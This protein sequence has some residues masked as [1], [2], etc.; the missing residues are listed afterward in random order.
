MRNKRMLLH[1]IR[2]L[3]VASFFFLEFYTEGRRSLPICW[4]RRGWKLGKWRLPARRWGWDHIHIFQRPRHFVLWTSC[5]Y[6][7]HQ[8]DVLEDTIHNGSATQNYFAVEIRIPKKS[9]SEIT[10]RT[11]NQ[12]T[13]LFKY[14]TNKIHHQSAKQN[15]HQLIKS[16]LH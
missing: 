9:Y 6:K 16:F 3:P 13:I 1:Q 8:H 14:C 7:S 5:S 4:G 11:S 15:I 12:E 2:K 10:M